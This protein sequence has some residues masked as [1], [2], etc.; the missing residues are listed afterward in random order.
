MSEPSERPELT[1]IPGFSQPPPPRLDLPDPATT[2]GSPDPSNTSP[3]ATENPG[4]LRK[5]WAPKSRPGTSTPGT[6]TEASAK[7][8]AADVQDLAFAIIGMVF[9]G[10]AFLYRRRTRT[11]LRMPTD[12]ESKRISQPLARIAM[13]HT[14]LSVLSPDLADVVLAG[15]AFGAYVNKAP[16]GDG[17][18]DHPGNVHQGEP[19]DDD[20]QAHATLAPPDL[21]EQAV[22]LQEW[23]R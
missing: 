18:T 12:A 9:V 8:T 4:L 21:F 6:A 5:L 2:M 7:P 11:Q 19:V 14:D 16:L 17:P 20:G 15:T 22:N 3:L 13:R 1:P 10:A 23:N